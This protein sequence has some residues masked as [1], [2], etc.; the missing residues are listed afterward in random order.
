MGEFLGCGL[1]GWTL[2]VDTWNFL[3]LK[4][5]RIERRQTFRGTPSAE[6][7]PMEG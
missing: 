3:F 1:N 7:G 6:I 4:R 5:L 2:F